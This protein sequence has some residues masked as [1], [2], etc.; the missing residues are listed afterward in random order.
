MRPRY[1]QPVVRTIGT[2]GRSHYTCGENTAFPVCDNVHYGFLKV[3]VTADGKVASQFIDY[4][5]KVIN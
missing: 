5:G 2:G 3:Y 1:V 4:N